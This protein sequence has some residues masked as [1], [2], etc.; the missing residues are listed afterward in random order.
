MR[1]AESVFSVDAIYYT[2]LFFEAQREE[3]VVSFVLPMT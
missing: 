3:G 2:D 1:C